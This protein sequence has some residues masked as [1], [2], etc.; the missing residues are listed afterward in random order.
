MDNK[1]TRT[2]TFF[3]AFKS[4]AKAKNIYILS[5]E[6][7]DCASEVSFPTEDAT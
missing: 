5:F 2:M 3:K 1:K 7:C 6:V 4:N